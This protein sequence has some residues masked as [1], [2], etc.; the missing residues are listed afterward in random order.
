MMWRGYA[1]IAAGLKAHEGVAASLSRDWRATKELLER[2]ALDVVQA[3][4]AEWWIYR[5]PQNRG[6]VTCL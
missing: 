2:G 6:L 4:L 3:N 5:V 1:K